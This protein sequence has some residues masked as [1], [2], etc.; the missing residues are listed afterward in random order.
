MSQPFDHGDA[1]RTVPENLIPSIKALFLCYSQENQSELVKLLSDR[2][3]PTI[4]RR[5]P[6]LQDFIA[7]MEEF[8][9]ECKANPDKDFLLF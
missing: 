9:M 1:R 3:M 6:S 7:S 8:I 5:N 2:I 4:K